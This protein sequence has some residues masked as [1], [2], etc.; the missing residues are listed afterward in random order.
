M[1]VLR[2]LILTDSLGEKLPDF[3]GFLSS[4]GWPAES[5]TFLPCKGEPRADTLAQHVPF[6]L[7]EYSEHAGNRAA[8]WRAQ[9]QAF[10]N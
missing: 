1:Q 2:N 7:G 10:T 5:L 6:K 4:L 8:A 3:I 9:V